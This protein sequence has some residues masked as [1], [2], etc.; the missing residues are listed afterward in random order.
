[1]Y[2]LKTLRLHT[3][4]KEEGTERENRFVMVIQ[5]REF[6]RKDEGRTS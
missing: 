5:R 1:M 4:P 3:E 6:E 2:Q